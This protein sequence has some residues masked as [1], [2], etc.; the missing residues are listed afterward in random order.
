MTMPSLFVSHGAPT[1]AIKDGAARRFLQNLGAM[2]E[3]PRAI[4]IM[5]AHHD[6]RGRGA[7]I[8]TSADHKAVHDFGGFPKELYELSYSPPGFPDLAREVISA[9]EHNSFDIF[10]DTSE[11]MDH[12]AWVPL[13]LMYPQ[14]DIPVIRISIDVT[15]SPEWHFR[16]GE[17]LQEFRERGVLIMGSGSITHNLQEFFQGGYRYEDLAPI[18][19]TSFADWFANQ[20][21]QGNKPVVLE[22]VSKGPNGK[23]NHPSMDHILPL[24]F[25][26]GAGGTNTLGLRLHQSTTYGVLSMDMYGFGEI[27]ALSAL[28]Q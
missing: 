25:A 24:F 11:E 28:K 5:S 10:E 26:M 8:A 3:K 1:L 18:W 19:V 6:G 27:N 22:A 9:L 15:R 20:I 12:G 23:R 4:L 16:L 21:E 2:M 14:A 13:L 7:T 17:A